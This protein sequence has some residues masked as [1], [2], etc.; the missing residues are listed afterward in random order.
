M[1][2]E[3][4]RNSHPNLLILCCH[5]VYDKGNIYSEFPED[6]VVYEQHLKES[7]KA[8]HSRLYETLIISG[9]YTKKQVEKSEAQGMLD[10]AYHLALNPDVSRI[11]L[12]EYARDSFENVL[13]GM[14][15]FYQEYNRFPEAVTICSWKPKKSR[16]RLITDGL[17]IPNYSF[18][19]IGEK[20][21]V[22]E[23]ET[24]LVKLVYGDPL[25]RK[26]ALT[27]MRRNRDPWG[28]GNPY[29][30]IEEFREMFEVLSFMEEK[31]L[32]DP[33]LVEP[34]WTHKLK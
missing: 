24:N 2:S 20:D 22:V 29:D 34:P 3:K 30:E 9:G 13:F 31:G 10:W 27:T 1:V 6:R 5:C 4:N 18:F 33:S 32:T 8:L 26:R 21:D 28:K 11:V 14:C 23:R 25:H 19:G 16:F 15:R 17:Q 7:I 12:E